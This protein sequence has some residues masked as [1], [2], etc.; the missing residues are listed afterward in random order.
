MNSVVQ[1]NYELVGRTFVDTDWEIECVGYSYSFKGER[2]TN[3]VVH[4]QATVTLQEEKFLIYTDTV[5]VS[6]KG[7]VLTCEPH[8]DGCE[9]P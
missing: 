1:T 7:L 4:I 9:T 2:F 3:V 6:S 8:E 5:K